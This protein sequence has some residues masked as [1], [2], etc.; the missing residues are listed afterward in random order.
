MPTYVALIKWT[1]EG[2][3]NVKDTVDRA[4]NAQSLAQS[5][6]ANLHTIYWLQGSEYD[7][8]ALVDAPDEET[9][10]AAL[11]GSAS[12]SGAIR[13]QT[14]RAYTEEEMRRIIQRIS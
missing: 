12:R 5:L 3:R 11:L 6:G 10:S 2:V 13:T 9:A 7:V 8:V 14:A 1:D 4:Q